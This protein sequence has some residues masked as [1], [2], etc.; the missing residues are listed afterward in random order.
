MMLDLLSAK[1]FQDN[2]TP[3]W[4][5]GPHVHEALFQGYRGMNLLSWLWYLVGREFNYTSKLNSIPKYLT[6]HSSIQFEVPNWIELNC[7]EPCFFSHCTNEDTLLLCLSSSLFDLKMFFPDSVG[8][9]I[10]TLYWLPTISWPVKN[11]TG[12]MVGVNYLCR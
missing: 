9:Y 11:L 3:E 5:K 12:L 6:K 7:W 10:N 2:W 4:P 8:I 1:T